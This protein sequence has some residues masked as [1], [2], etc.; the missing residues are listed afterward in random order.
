MAFDA[1]LIFETPGD[2]APP[3]EGET[4]DKGFSTKKAM[5]ISEFSF[6]IENT[7]SIG[8]ATGG[9]GA[10]KATF[11]EFTTKKV[12]DTASPSLFKT[13]TTGGHYGKVSLYIRKAG[14]GTTG[15]PYLMFVFGTVAVKSIEW[16]G[17]SG[18]DVPTENVVF[19]YGQIA[20][21]YSKQS[22]SGALEA[23]APQAW[24]RVLNAPWES[25]DATNPPAVPK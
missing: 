1:F 6:G 2:G 17:S 15:K 22:P 20:I 18:D 5:E 3:L 25:G 21:F 7:L 8:S 23:R 10:G 14:G 11:K 12:T 16:S 9:A 19:E 4:M 13:C 24:D